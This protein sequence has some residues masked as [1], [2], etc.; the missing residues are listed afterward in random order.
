MRSHIE[1][2]ADR[3]ISLSAL[4]GTIGLI[5]E[6]SVIIID[7]IGRYFGHPLTGARDMS[8]MAMVVVVFG[9]M[10]MCDKVGGHISVDIFESKFPAIVNKLSDIIS[11]LIGAVIFLILAW[12][13]WESS[14]LSRMLNLA[15][16]IIYLPKAWFQYIAIFMSLI[17]ALGMT[18]RA[19]SVAYPRS[20]P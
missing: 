12:T 14:V 9:G 8:Q 2:W 16:N 19:L 13:L 3:L 7:V 15:T 11:P 20:N 17:T 5:V 10:A 4:I 1:T 6:V 18:L